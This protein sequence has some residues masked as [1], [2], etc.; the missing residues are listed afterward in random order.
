MSVG[1]DSE[2]DRRSSSQPNKAQAT[3]HKM[4]MSGP[5]RGFDDE[6]RNDSSCRRDMSATTSA[7]ELYRDVRDADDFSSNSTS[8]RSSNRHSI[9]AISKGMIRTFQTTIQNNSRSQFLM[10]ENAPI[11]PSIQ[12]RLQKL[13]SEGQRIVKSV[14]QHAILDSVSDKLVTVNDRLGSI[15]LL[16]S[17]SVGHN[18]NNINNSFKSWSSS[19][20]SSSSVPNCG[21]TD[22]GI[23]SSQSMRSWGSTV[24]AE[25][26]TFASQKM[27][28]LFRRQNTYPF[29]TGEG[30]HGNKENVVS[31]DYQL[32][33]DN[34]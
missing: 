31:F 5:Y 25:I 3:D 16:R 13:A 30:N 24:S 14:Q 9:S 23:Y 10:P 20:S 26:T 7:D 17:N 18:N 4:S 15:L 6:Q 34:E 8:G 19:S 12:P 1:D 2:S 11:S 28:P 29:A 22:R 27:V 33:K 32:M 21:S